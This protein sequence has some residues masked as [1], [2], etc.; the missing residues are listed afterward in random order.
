MSRRRFLVTAIAAAI[1]GAGTS[2]PAADRIADFQAEDPIRSAIDRTM[3]APIKAGKVAGASISV[4][5]HG[6]TIVS[7]SY[8][9]AD[10][11]LDVPMPADA[12]FEIGSVTKQFT[13]ASILLLAERGRLSVADEVTKFLPDYPTHGQHITIRHLLT[14]TSGIKGYTEMSEFGDLMALKKPRETLVTLFGA[15]P[16]DFMP[17]EAL[18]Y[19]NSAYFLL[20]LIVE[21]LS[22]QTYADFVRT[23]LFEKAGMPGSYYCS[24]S[25]IHH[26]HAHGYDTDNGT[27]V[28]KGFISHVWPYSAGSLCSTAADLS[29]WLTALHGGRI[30]NADSYRAMTTPTALAAGTKTRYGFGVGVADVGGRRAIFHGGGINGFL[31]EV[32]YFPDS[33][34]SIV[35]LLN[36]AGPVGPADLAREIADSVLGKA[37]EQPVRFTGD[38][39]AY[40]GTFEGVGRGRRTTITIAADGDTLTMKGSGPPSAPAQTLTYRGNDTFAVKETLLIF[41]R[42]A[43]KVTR[44]RLDSVFGHYPLTKS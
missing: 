27:L 19:N 42:D 31:S 21:K 25:A 28:L 23:N 5:R 17:G 11:E 32:E 22:G 43:G 30:L 29:A 20:G 2:H 7:K 13:A 35:V 10:L 12:S 38:L 1:V 14:H 36:T 16:L 8:G 6:E 34:L 24:E 3:E 41:E 26:H 9:S 44:L 18:V 33:G 40:A 37:T 15:K 4:M 39:H